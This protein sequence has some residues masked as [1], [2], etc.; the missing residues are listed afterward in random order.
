M[1]RAGERRGWRMGRKKERGREEGAVIWGEAIRASGEWQA[2]CDL[3][4]ERGRQ[5]GEA[6]AVEMTGLLCPQ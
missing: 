6:R 1:A 5:S 3:S 2:V 4:I